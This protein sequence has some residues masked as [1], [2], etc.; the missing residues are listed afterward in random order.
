MTEIFL[1]RHIQAE[2]N[3]YRMMQG[4]WDGGVTR[5]GLM[6]RDALAE[7]FRTEKLDA[8][9]SSD[10]YRALVTASGAAQYHPG[11][12][13][14][15]SKAFRELNVGP[16]EK[17]FFGD[18]LYREPENMRLFMYD[19]EK[20]SYDGAETFPEAGARALEELK[21]VISERPGQRI[22]VVSHGVTLRSMLS[23]ITGVP[24]SDTE[25]LPICGNASVTKLNYSDG[26]F[27]I[28]Y[29]NDM[30]HLG[31]MPRWN[32]AVPSLR[33]E[34]LSPVA[35]AVRYCECYKDA[36]MAAHGNLKGF[37][38]DTYLMSVTSRCRADA[39]GVL[40]LFDG[41]TP[42]G[43]I[44]MD[45]L[46]GADSGI[47]WIAFLY[48]SPEYRGRGLGIQLLARAI[49]H[50]RELG[51]SVI[52]LNVAESNAPARAFYKKWGFTETSYTKGAAGRLIVMERSLDTKSTAL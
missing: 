1:I 31:T 40:K 22:A 19:S 47:G 27:S 4:Q 8:V 41:D 24:L 33:A 12:E 42:A 49:M 13:I 38:A 44:E 51:R 26:E 29:F 14:I 7:R 17:R 2:G 21:R 36:W 35:D 52:C 10:L 15:K 20:W 16:L 45:T 9:V 37:Y 18:I 43:I 11:L 6:Q 3:L 50:Y 48:L 32:G 46:R 30:S 23:L 34:R 39:D 28:E 25:H 5:L